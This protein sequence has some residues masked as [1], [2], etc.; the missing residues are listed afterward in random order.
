MALQLMAITASLSLFPRE[1]DAMVFS[2]KQSST[3]P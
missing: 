1:D 3:P 2:V